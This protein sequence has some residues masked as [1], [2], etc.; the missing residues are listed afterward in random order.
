MRPKLLEIEGLQSFTEAQ[1]IDFDTLGESGLFGIFGPTGSGKST[2]LDAITFALYG[3]VKRA[4]GGTQG[5]I[6][7]RC[8]KARVAF[9][10]ELSR[11]GT[12][13]S[14]R[15]ERTY[16]R[17]KNTPNA[18]EPKVVRL[19]ELTAD[20]DIP[21]CDKATE[22][23]SKIRELLGLNSEDFTRAVVIP[24]NSF[25]EFLLLNNSE[26][27]GMLERIFYLEEYGRQLTDKIARKIAGLKSRI[28]V[29]TG[30]LSGYADASPEAL[31]EAKRAMEAA[32][33]DNENVQKELK[34]I[35]AAYNKAREI[36]GLVR[37]IEDI[38]RKEKEHRTLEQEITAK[39]HKL[40]KA[41]KA[42]SLAAIISQT[43]E[44]V[45]GWRIQ[46]PN[47]RV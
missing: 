31:E 47:C 5:I 33:Q 22:V 16:Q 11:N 20:G 6:N 21:L 19:I 15:V 36:W 12:R 26:R 30:E 41:V 9:T 38:D 37:D 14:Y 4:E 7:S 45:P 27:R 8:G 39:R 25:Q 44:L 29:L 46:M 23:S 3:R 32:V 1:T 10:F 42:D 13:T 35:V 43:R 40:D 18:C 28:D 2:I 17:K 24:Q 34:E